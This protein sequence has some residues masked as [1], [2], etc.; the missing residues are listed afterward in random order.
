MSIVPF[1]IP[2]WAELIATGLGGLQGALF[3]A[4]FRDRRIDVFGV[5]VIGIGVALGGS[6]LRDVLLDERPAVVWSGWYLPVAAA[7][8]LAGMVLQAVIR[9]VG[10][11]VNVLD[12][13]VIG[14]FGAIAASKALSLGVGAVGAAVMIGIIGAVGGSILRDVLLGLPIAF[15]QVGSLYAVAAGA[16]AVA[17]VL[18][19]AVG[20]P[21]PVAGLISL[22]VTAVIRLCAV[23]FDWTLPEQGTPSWRRRRSLRAPD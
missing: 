11:A 18:L 22:T 9:R 4:G 1:A 14:T 21:V 19:I 3:A 20:T 8:A 15:L 10:W 23:H 16:G 13:V 2:L 17:V 6:L 7:S 5:M 12:A